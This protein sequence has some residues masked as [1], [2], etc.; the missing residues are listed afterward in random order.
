[1][2]SEQVALETFPE[3]PMD[4]TITPTRGRSS[5]RR[6]GKERPASGVSQRGP[7]E[8][9]LRLPTEQTFDQYVTQR[10]W[11][12]ASLPA[13]PLCEPGT[14]HFHRLGTYMRKVPSVAYVTRYVCRKR[15]TSFSLLPDFYAS[16]MPGT[17]DMIEQAAA[18]A[19]EA[20]SMEKAA[21]EARPADA[22]D[23]VTLGA[24]HD[25]AQRAQVK[26]TGD[27]YD[28]LVETFHR[29]I[30]TQV[31][32]A[33][34]MPATVIATA[35]HWEAYEAAGPMRLEC[36]IVN[37]AHR[38]ANCTLTDSIRLSRDLLVVEPAYQDLG[39]A[40]VDAIALFDAAGSINADLDT[41]LPP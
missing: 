15:H 41:Y 4:R 36:N 12:T 19:E 21:E 40:A 29:H 37:V 18:K 39:F 24:A 14:C 27:E 2:Q 17:L 11:E 28:R 8:V 1:M 22:P 5:R 7:G 6:R 13:C 3:S 10:G 23:A 35:T 33:W 25:L 38:L 16:R 20:S 9:Q 30:G 26:L 34:G 31:L 32:S